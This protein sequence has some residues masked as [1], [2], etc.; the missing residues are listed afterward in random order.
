M[1]YTARLKALREDNDDT[2]KDI[3]EI[4]KIKHQQYQRYESGKTEMPIRYLIEICKHY[5]VSA[6]YL[7]GLPKELEWPR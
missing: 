7:L 2:Q 3:A 4:L 5:N 6:D 1:P